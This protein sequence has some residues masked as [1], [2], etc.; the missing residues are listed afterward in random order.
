MSP[1][2]LIFLK[3]PR[4]GFV[5]TRLAKD[6]G[7]EAACQI[8]RHLAEKT[9]SQIP[10]DWP[11]HI[12]FTPSDAEL[13]IR[14]W[15][16]KKPQYHPQSEGDLGLRLSTACEQAFTAG[17]SSVVLLGGD[18]PGIQSEHLKIAAQELAKGKSVI[19][20]ARDGGYWLLGLPKHCPEVFEK[21]RWSTSEVFSITQK[22]LQDAQ[23]PPTLLPTLED[24]DDL[25]SWSRH[26]EL[27]K[28]AINHFPETL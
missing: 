20:P 12:Y 27:K 18:C 25:Q 26:P 4:P 14:D 10:C 17:A 16:G 11:C 1:T 24:V 5:K 7:N 21:I 8:Y 22:H 28:F 3:T 15:L 9:L 6:L 23:L 2:A 19:G 13:E